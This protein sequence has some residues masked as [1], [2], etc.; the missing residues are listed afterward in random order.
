MQTKG[1]KGTWHIT[2]ES[3][4]KFGREE[5]LQSAYEVILP[6]EQ[7]KLKGDNSATIKVSKNR[8]V[9]KSIER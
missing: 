7:I 2:T 4:Y 1:K 8:F 5:K 6:T 9:C 3:V